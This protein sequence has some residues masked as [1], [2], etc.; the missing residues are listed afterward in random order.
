MK[1]IF[2]KIDIDRSISTMIHA[3][4]MSHI[5][6]KPYFCLCKNK[7]AVT[8]QLISAFDFAIWIVK[9]QFFLNPKF[10]AFSHFLP[11]PFSAGVYRPVC[12]RPGQKSGRHV[13][14]H[15]GS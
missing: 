4:Y 1:L 7:G 13:F 12:V 2:I 5:M 11:E 8:A 14:S 15:C 3:Y 6:R 9:F 10:Q